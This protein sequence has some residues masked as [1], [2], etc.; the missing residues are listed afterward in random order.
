MAQSSDHTKGIITLST[1]PPLLGPPYLVLKGKGQPLSGI[2]SVQ[3][4]RL[5]L[6]RG[7][8]T[9]TWKMPLIPTR[10]PLST[11]EWPVPLASL[12]Q[13]SQLPYLCLSPCPSQPH[14][15]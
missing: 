4:S 15:S 13:K 9:P 8:G 7:L 10:L 1:I 12:G 14:P 6:G 11:E 3:P 5:L 2:Q